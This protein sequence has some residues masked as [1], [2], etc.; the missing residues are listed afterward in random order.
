MGEILEDP[1]IMYVLHKT[2][3]FRLS[4]QAL[5][6]LQIIPPDFPAI[7]AAGAGMK[8][9]ACGNHAMPAHTNQVKPC[10]LGFPIIWDF[11]HLKLA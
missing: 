6:A 4:K 10:N 9:A 2:K 3:S 11:F 1:V 8:V 5:V 7:G